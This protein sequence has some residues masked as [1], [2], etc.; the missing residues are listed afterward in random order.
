MRRLGIYVMYD[1]ENIVDDYIGYMLWEMRKVVDCL[2]V[3][4]NCEEISSGSE[5]IENYADKIYYRDNIGFDVGAYKHALCYRLGWD[6]IATYEELVLLNDSFYGPFYP[7]EDLF[8][9]MEKSDADYWGLTRSPAGTLMGEYIYDT[10]I[11]SYFLVFRKSVLHDKRFRVFW[12]EM[13]YPESFMQAVRVFEL[14]C[15]KLMSEWGWKGVALSDLY[16]HKIPI[17]TDEN[18]YMVC[19]YE[20]ICDAK[21]P[22]LKRKS[23]DLRFPGFSNAFKAF[24]Y[25]ENQ[26]IYDVRLIKKHMQ[27]IGQPL[28]ERAKLDFVKL[29]EFY[30]T[31]ARIYLYGAGTCGKNLAEYFDYKGWSFE[32]FLVTVHSSPARREILFDEAD[33]TKQDGI[34]VAVGTEEAYSSIIDAVKKRCTKE[35]I[36]P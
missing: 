35:Q 19:S 1:Y 4:C 26:G 36:Y 28:H 2:V 25:I 32:S 6:E 14:E 13:P 29:N 5:H 24:Q 34:I 15:N 33:I 17:K 9:R 12:E 20:L 31:H 8:L 7:I 30:H 21:V 22:V 3:V 16:E 27:R 10:H 23:L 18:P 11:Q